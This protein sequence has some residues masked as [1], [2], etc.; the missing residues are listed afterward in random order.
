MGLGFAFA[1]HINRP[2]AV[3]A[4]NLYRDQFQPSR[5]YAEPHAILAVSVI[6]GENEDH[7]R[8]LMEIAEV[9]LWRL[10]TNKQAPAPTL[11]EARAVKLTQLQ[12]L[13]MS[14][15][16]ANMIVGDTASVTA[17]VRSMAESSRAD[18]VMITPMLAGQEDR[19]RTIRQFHQ[20]WTG[21]APLESSQPESASIAAPTPEPSFTG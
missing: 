12:R 18:E 19:L 6:I 1:S 21:S 15:M 10:L 9:Q 2:A 20:T 7:A 17:Q 4:M 8:D 3:Q 5:R 16:T 13:Q 11:E 14:S